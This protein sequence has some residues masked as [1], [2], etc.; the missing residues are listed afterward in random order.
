MNSSEASGEMV[1][2]ITADLSE[3]AAVIFALSN[4]DFYQNFLERF[5]AASGR[6]LRLPWWAIHLGLYFGIGIA[7]VCFL[8]VH[9]MYPNGG[10]ISFG[11]EQVGEF[12]FTA[13]MLWHLRKSRSAAVLTAARIANGRDRIIWLRKYLAPVS[14]GW[15]VRFGRRQWA[16]RVWFLNV[17]L[18]T[19]YWGSQFLHYRVAVHRFPHSH[20]FWA[21]SYPYPQLLYIYP[22]MAKAAMAIAGVAHFWLLRGMVSVVRGRYPSNLSATEKESLYLECGQT[23]TQ[24]SLGVSAAIVIWVLARALAYG[25]TFWAYLYSFCLFVVFA[26]Q[27]VIITDSRFPWISAPFL[28]QLIAPNFAMEWQVA[29]IGGLILGLGPMAQ[30]IGAVAGAR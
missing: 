12:M 4:S 27:V 16:I 14:W 2:A 22:T 5:L 1:K 3:E 29:G 28:R 11:A 18:L 15:V 20:D 24:F 19:A 13:F 8:N 30:I 26:G 6:L 17:A 9:E 25:F 23:A 7:F 21:V 10:Y